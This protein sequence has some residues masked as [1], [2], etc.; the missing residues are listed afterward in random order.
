MK[1]IWYKSVIRETELNAKDA[2]SAVKE[3]MDKAYDLGYTRG[4]EAGID[5]IFTYNPDED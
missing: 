2:T 3:L 5:Y 1:E 4:C